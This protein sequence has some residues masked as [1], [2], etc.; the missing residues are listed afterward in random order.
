M[1]GQRGRGRRWAG[2]FPK[3]KAFETSF[4]YFFLSGL[5]CFEEREGKN[6]K[7]W[8]SGGIKINVQMNNFCGRELAALKNIF[9]NYYTHESTGSFKLTHFLKKIRRRMLVFKS[10][11]DS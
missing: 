3:L 11:F 7:R 6:R 9:N 4:S 10:L 1:D 5:F 8:G 2:A